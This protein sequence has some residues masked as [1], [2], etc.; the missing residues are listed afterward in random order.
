[1]PQDQVRSYPIFSG[2]RDLDQ[3]GPGLLFPPAVPQRASEE[4]GK[5]KKSRTEVQHPQPPLSNRRG[6]LPL[7]EG[8]QEEM[9]LFTG[10]RECNTEGSIQTT[11]PSKRSA[12][13][14]NRSSRGTFGVD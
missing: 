7:I 13:L 12:R 2:G 9:C 3:A 4:Q 14:Y 1:M 10:A 8:M 5:L 11:G 6:D